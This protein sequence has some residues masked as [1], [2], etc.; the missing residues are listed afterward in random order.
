MMDIG[1]LDIRGLTRRGYR[2]GV[3]QTRALDGQ[4]HDFNCRFAQD[5]GVLP[6]SCRQGNGPGSAWYLDWRRWS[7]VRVNPGWWARHREEP[8]WP[9]PVGPGK[10]RI[11]GWD[12]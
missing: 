7:M 2:R 11:E 5:Q 10:S 12:F 8:K 1:S 9:V 6:C 4:D 3:L